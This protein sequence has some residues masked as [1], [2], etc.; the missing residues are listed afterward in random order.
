MVFGRKN[1]QA[2][3][4]LW[5]QIAVIGFWAVTVS[6]LVKRTWFSDES[7]MVEV[8]PE[9][10]LEMFF[11]WTEGAELAILKD[12]QNIGQMSLST[13]EEKEIIRENGERTDLLREVSMAGSLN[14]FSSS[15][16]KEAAGTGGQEIHWRGALSMNEELNF[17]KGDFI[18]SMPNLGLGA[19]LGFDQV[20]GI[21]SVNVRSKDEKFIEY[22]GKP[23]GLAKLPKLG[24][25]GSLFPLES[26]LGE[27]EMSQRT[28][29]A[30]APE[31]SGYYGR[32]M[33][34]GRKMMVYQL[35]VNRD[36]SGSKSGSEVRLYLSEVGEP[37][38][39]RTKWGY[40]AVAS[41]LVP[42]EN[43]LKDQ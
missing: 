27:Q 25:I 3:G 24:W 7:G 35:I 43:D 6:I 22:R 9:R 28:L 17:P 37:L 2:A 23:E 16:R 36:S 13:Q 31:I 4:I 39:L 33:I 40:E 10:I 14:R 11:A 32:A 8:A 30:W 1:S 21:I 15:N 19:Q 38:M 26:L 34:A 20:E 5:V 29:K 12:G 41:V 42:V 18:L